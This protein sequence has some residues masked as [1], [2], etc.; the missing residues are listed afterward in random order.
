MEVSRRLFMW[1]GHLCLK[2]FYLFFYIAGAYIAC[3][4]RYTFLDPQSA[5]A[6]PLPND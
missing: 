2:F 5:R 6:N 4:E 1:Q 3:N